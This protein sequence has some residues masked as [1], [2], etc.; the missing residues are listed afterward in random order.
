MALGKLYEYAVLH[1]FKP[2]KSEEEQGKKSVTTL[3]VEPTRVIAADEGKVL[4]IAAS[5]IPS[6]YLDGK[7]DEIEVAIR[8][9]LES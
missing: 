6:E 2:N 9:F 5:K 3:L 1:H 8:P 7:L 4:M